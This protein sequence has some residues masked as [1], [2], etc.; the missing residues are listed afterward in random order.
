[1]PERVKHLFEKVYKDAGVGTE[2]N[3]DR[4][5]YSIANQCKGQ[6]NKRSKYSETESLFLQWESGSAPV[7]EVKKFSR[8]GKVRYYEKTESGCVELS[9]SQ[10]NERNGAYAENIDRRAERETGETAD[11]DES[12]QR[13]TLGYNHSDRNPHGN[14]T[15]FGQT[16]REELPNVTAGSERSSLG[17]DRRTDINQSEY[18]DEASDKSGASFITFSNDYAAVRNYM[19]ESAAGKKTDPPVKMSLCCRRRTARQSATGLLQGQHGNKEAGNLKE[20]HHGFYNIEIG[21]LVRSRR[22][23]GCTS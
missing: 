1:M 18:T 17:H 2:S 8:S 10:Y 9:R 20:L 16:I 15:V 23:G 3:V 13:G 11:Y 7:G 21:R 22:F 14:A 6:Y 5:R 12:A 19:K 4:T